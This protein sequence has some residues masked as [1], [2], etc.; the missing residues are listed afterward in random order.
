MT[1]GCGDPD[2]GEGSEVRSES[3]LLH[4]FLVCMK[5]AFLPRLPPR[6]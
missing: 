5:K 2:G 6:W 1:I 4:D 3:D